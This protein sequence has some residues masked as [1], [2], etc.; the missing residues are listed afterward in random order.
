MSVISAGLISS[1][2]P[3]A[4]SKMEAGKTHA[5][6]SEPKAQTTADLSAEAMPSALS[7]EMGDS[8]AE[9]LNASGIAASAILPDVDG[10]DS[11]DIAV[12]TDVKSESVAELDVMA[13]MPETKESDG[14]RE[15]K[16]AAPAFEAAS[17]LSR[18]SAQQEL[19]VS[20]YQAA[21]LNEEIEQ[22]IERLA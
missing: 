5:D 17:D 3:S 12:S 11:G 16:N 19:L 20:K 15:N 18:L 2:L 14:V 7:Q 6:S 9:S 8:A 4:P 22:I 21:K 10:R 13:E 1:T